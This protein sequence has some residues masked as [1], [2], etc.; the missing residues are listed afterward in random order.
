MSEIVIY[1]KGIKRKQ[2][3]KLKDFLSTR[4]ARV[5]KIKQDGKELKI[6]PTTEDPNVISKKKL[7]PYLKRFIYLEG[8]KYEVKVLSD[9]ENRLILHRKG[10]IEPVEEEEVTPSEETEGEEEGE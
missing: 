2:V 3:S 8:E 9:G 10:G 4:F 7:K 5:A 1:G 6:K